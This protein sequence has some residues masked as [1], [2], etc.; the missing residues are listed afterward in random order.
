MCWLINPKRDPARHGFE[1]LRLA[2]SGL[3]D[4]FRDPE[5]TVAEDAGHFVHYETPDP[6]SAVIAAFFH[7]VSW[8]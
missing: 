8:R 4:Y 7:R 1:L 2:A 5:V 6:A 3:P